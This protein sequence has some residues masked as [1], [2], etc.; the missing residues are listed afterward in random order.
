MSGTLRWFALAVLL[1]SAGTAAT[2]APLT[3]R[4]GYAADQH[5]GYSVDADFSVAPSE[6]LTFL[7]GAGHSRG[8]DETGDL[9]GTLYNVGVSWRGRRAGVSLNYDAF[10][11]SSD[12]RAG[13]LGARAWLS[14]GDF[15]LALLGRRRDLAVE[16][17]LELPLRTLRRELDFSATG[18]GLELGYTREDF[19]AYVMALQYDYDESFDDFLDLIGSPQLE[20]RPRIEALVGTFITQ[21]QGAVD[22]LAGAGVEFGSGRHSVGLDITFAH[23]AVLD[24]GSTSLAVSYRRVQSARIDWGVSAGL[25]DSDAFGDIGFLGVDIGLSN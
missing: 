21:T 2:A 24:S 13:T 14:A 15:E 9:T 8:S 16:V 25:V 17:V 10:D 4:F 20:R 6:R 22:R 12:Y 11:D 19:S 18:V 7:A 3:A 1:A 23:D 5:G